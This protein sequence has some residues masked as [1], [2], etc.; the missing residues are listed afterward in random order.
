MTSFKLKDP[1]SISFN[2]NFNHNEIKE[3]RQTIGK[4][5]ETSV[6]SAFA[7]VFDNKNKKVDFKINYDSTSAGEIDIEKGQHNFSYG[8][9]SLPK[10]SVVKLNNQNTLTFVKSDRFNDLNDFKLSVINN[11]KQNTHYVV[12]YNLA[13]PLNGVSNFSARLTYNT[14]DLPQTT[15]TAKG[16]ERVGLHSATVVEVPGRKLLTLVSSINM[17]VLNYYSKTLQIIISLK[18]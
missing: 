12:M 1:G 7:Q 2:L 5:Q 17:M 9:L 11:N 14:K 3:A 15:L 8:T 6:V 10:S 4:V 18:V 16:V 13:F